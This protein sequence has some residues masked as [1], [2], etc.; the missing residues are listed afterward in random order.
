MDKGEL[1]MNRKSDWIWGLALIIAGLGFGGDA[2]GYWNFEV[3]FEGWWTLFIIVPCTVN[4]FE[5]GVHRGNLIGLGIGVILLLESWIP[6]LDDLIFPLILV[7][8]GLAL[9][10]AN[11]SSVSHKYTLKKDG[12]AQDE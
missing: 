11:P 1:R 12:K 6:R 3:F 7:L 10:L 8:I 5:K 2:L 9:I 4:I